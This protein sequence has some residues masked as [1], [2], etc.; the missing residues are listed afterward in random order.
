MKFHHNDITITIKCDEIEHVHMT[1]AIALKASQGI[2][3]CDLN[4]EIL[5]LLDDAKWQGQKPH[6]TNSMS[7]TVDKLIEN[8]TVSS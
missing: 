8:R 5:Q 3:H 7:L 2:S 4:A 1:N 6:V